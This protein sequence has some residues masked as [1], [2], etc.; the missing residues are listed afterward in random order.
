MRVSILP[1]TLRNRLLLIS[2]SCLVVTFLGMAAV[3]VFGLPHGLLPGG[4]RQQEQEALARL[5]AVADNKKGALALWF[6]ERLGDLEMASQHPLLA[7]FLAQ[8]PLLDPAWASTVTGMDQSRRDVV[9]W[10]QNLRRTHPDYDAL[11]LVAA[12]E[13]AIILSTEQ[14]RSGGRLPLPQETSADPPLPGEHFVFFVRDHAGKS[15]HLCL[16]I[17]LAPS[18]VAATPTALVFHVDTATLAAKLQD[19]PLLGASGEILLVDMNRTLLTPL[20]HPLGGGAEAIPLQSRIETRMAQYAAL[21]NDGIMQAPDY[22]GVLVLGAVRH[23]RVLPDFGLGMVVKQDRA[24]VFAPIYRRLGILVAIA[25]SGLALVL[26]AIFVM[27]RTLLRPVEMVTAAA[28]RLRDGELSAR[29]DEHGSGEARVLAIAFNVMA[30]E[31]QRWHEIADRERAELQDFNRII[32]DHAPV[33]IAVYD[34]T[35]QCLRANQAVADASGATIDHLVSQN[36]HDLASWK[37]CGLFDLAVKAMASE[38]MV[39]GFVHIL[40]SFGRE[41][42]LHARFYRLRCYNDQLILI[43]SDLTELKMTQDDLVRMNQALQAR[44]RQLE[45]ANAELESFNHTVSHDLRTPI[46]ALAGFPDLLESHLGHCL[47]AKGRQYL[48]A[49]RVAARRMAEITTKLLDFSRLGRGEISW[50]DVD[51][52]VLVGKV[53]EDLAVMAAGR[54]ITWQVADLPVVKGDANLLRIALTNL[55]ANAIKFTSLKEHAVIGVASAVG[56][57]GLPVFTVKDNGAGFDMR[58]ADR[59]FT[60]FSRLHP[61]EEFE[62]TGIGLATVNRIVRRHGGRIWAEGTPGAGASFSFTLTS[63]PS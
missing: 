22:R 63:P 2:S 14:G 5:D 38:V 57:D 49:I 33:G 40:T 41:A 46:R 35:G 3:I 8:Q 36:F 7:T 6:S 25:C 15:A 19:T 45:A 23:I 37:Q 39:E 21:G 11:D 42:W 53:R 44:S 52:S 24:E 58:Y 27:A 48:D 54:R 47:D 28:C 32:V 17:H 61:S 56:E 26:T 34:E 16:A 62:G 13:G 9:L 29:A 31:V 30:E 18:G 12:R 4:L 59:L 43:I 1:H 50:A 10:L 60:V 55:L 51:L 20:R